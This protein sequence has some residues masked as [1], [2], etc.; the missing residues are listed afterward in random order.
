MH[1]P[2]PDLIPIDAKYFHQQLSSV[3]TVKTEVGKYEI[4]FDET[5]SERRLTATSVLLG[6]EKLPYPLCNYSPL[7]KAVQL[8]HSDSIL[9][10]ALTEEFESITGR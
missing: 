10:S 9:S 7:H 5:R 8:R 3:A 1:S 4:V 2:D 6:G